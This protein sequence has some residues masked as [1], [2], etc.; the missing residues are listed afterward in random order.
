MRNQAWSKFQ[1]GPNF[2]GKEKFGGAVLGP[3]P[4]AASE[5]TLR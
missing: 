4:A 2:S 1:G 5:E 3:D